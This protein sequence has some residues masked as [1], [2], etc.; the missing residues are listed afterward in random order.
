MF[1]RAAAVEKNWLKS[2]KDIGQKST[3]TYVVLKIWFFIGFCGV[4][5][6]KKWFLKKAF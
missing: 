5:L 4:E 3:T 6:K 2:I 1:F